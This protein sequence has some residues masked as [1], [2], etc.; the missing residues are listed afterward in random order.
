MGLIGTNW[1][2]KLLIGNH[3]EQKSGQ[4][5]FSTR[6]RRKLDSDPNFLILGVVRKTV[7]ILVQVLC[8]CQ[9]A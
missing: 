3:V 6:C 4:Q 5:R 7:A 2:I 9:V 1:E 8:V